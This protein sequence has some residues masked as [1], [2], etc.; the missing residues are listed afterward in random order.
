MLDFLT[1]PL[2]SSNLTGRAYAAWASLIDDKLTRDFEWY[3]GHHGALEPPCYVQFCVIFVELKHSLSFL[4][5][6]IR[7]SIEYE[8]MGVTSLSSTAVL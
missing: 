3:I 2:Y 4:S 6:L 1:L 8:K 5:P 7:L